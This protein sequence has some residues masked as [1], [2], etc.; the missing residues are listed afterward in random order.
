MSWLSLQPSSAAMIGDFSHPEGLLGDGLTLSRKTF[1]KG[2]SACC[3]LL[4]PDLALNFNVKLQLENAW[5]G[6]SH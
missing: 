2:F 5:L 3:C 4:T 1:A 6:P